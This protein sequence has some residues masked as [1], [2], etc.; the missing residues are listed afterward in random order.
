[1]SSILS[2]E[3]DSF[4][5]IDVY[6]VYFIIYY[7]SLQYVSIKSSNKVVS[8]SS[9]DEYS[10]VTKEDSAKDFSSCSN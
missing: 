5:M 2:A 7:F 1:M 10:Y 3:C 6:D 8:T 9:Y 4:D